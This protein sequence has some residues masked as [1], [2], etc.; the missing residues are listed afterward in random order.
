M[1][2]AIAF[3]ILVLNFVIVPAWG[4]ATRRDRSSHDYSDYAVWAD[5]D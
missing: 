5:A 1:L 2:S 3:A 4:L